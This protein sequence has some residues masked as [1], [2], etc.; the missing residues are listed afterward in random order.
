MPVG[1]FW[2]DLENLP[3]VNV[4]SLSRTGFSGLARSSEVITGNI[5]RSLR[6]LGE[7]KKVGD[8]MDFLKTSKRRR[9]QIEGRLE[10]FPESEPGMVRMLSVM[11]TVGK[12]LYLGNSLP[13]R[14][15]ND[16]AQREY[17]YEL[18]RANRGANG[19]DGQIATW[20]GATSDEQDAWGVFG[21]LTTLYD[22]SAPALLSQ[23]QCQGRMLVVINNGGGQIF[24]RLPKVQGMDQE[25]ADLVTNEH[26]IGFESWAKM[27]GMNY[28]RVTGIENFDFEPA[29]VTTVIEVIPNAKQTETFLK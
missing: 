13:I 24:N 28:I 19:I 17:P 3:D 29:D 10:S 5:P 23:V 2:R 27:W 16:F 14:E 1:R 9:G 4:V 15:W 25:V 18:V 22:L 7:V 20:L 8:A 11:A 12:S 6:A 21:D 26:E